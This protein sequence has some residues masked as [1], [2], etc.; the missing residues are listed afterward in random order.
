M[1]S[2]WGRQINYSLFGESHGAGIGITLHHLP[3]GFRPD[4]V[5]I[6]QELDRRKPGTGVHATPRQE[7]DDYQILSGLYE[8]KLTGAPLTVFFPNTDTRSKDY[9]NLAVT[10]RPSHADYSAAMKYG[11]HQDYRG[12]GHFSGRLTAPVVF[13]GALAAQLLEALGVSIGSRICRIGAVTDTPEMLEAS[14]ICRVAEGSLKGKTLPFLSSQAE[15]AANA[16][17]AELKQQGDS[18]GGQVEVCAA[19]VPAGWGEPVFDSLEST[20]AHLLFSIPG[21]KA[22]EFGAG[23]GFAGMRGSEA[24]DP[25]TIEQG[26]V[27]STSNHSGGINGGISN[28]M[29]IRFRA[30]FRPTPSIALPQDT[31]DLATGSAAELKIHGRHDPCIVPRACPVVEAVTAM[32]LLEAM[33]DQQIQTQEAWG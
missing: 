5:R 9:Q 26:I 20:L 32:A 31:V 10:P 24:N 4:F 13:A 33:L 18:V 19:G 6:R 23:T 15:D 30:T 22:V 1:R 11:G 14:D 28:G 25:W 21:V 12:G 3:A 17:L 7:T 29:A 16:L 2:S 27:R 8:E